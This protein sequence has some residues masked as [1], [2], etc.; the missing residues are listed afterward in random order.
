MPYSEVVEHKN[1]LSPSAFSIII[2]NISSINSSGCYCRAVN[3]LFL[4]S[5]FFHRKKIRNYN[6]QCGDKVLTFLK[7]FYLP[8]LSVFLLLY[9]KYVDGISEQWISK[10]VQIWASFKFSLL[11]PHHSPSNRCR[12]LHHTI[13]RNIND[14]EFYEDMQHIKAFDPSIIFS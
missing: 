5:S 1:Q 4:S 2:I 12:R 9:L 3:Y 10:A 11:I 13:A 6:F 8:L 14:W 7:A